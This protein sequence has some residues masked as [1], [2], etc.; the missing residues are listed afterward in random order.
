MS[1]KFQS[2]S[3]EERSQSRLVKR[4]GEKNHH[5][6]R[7]GSEI[8]QGFPM[9]NGQGRPTV[10]STFCGGGEGYGKAIFIS[11]WVLFEV[12]I[13]PPCEILKTTP[14]PKQNLKFVDVKTKSQEKR[15][16]Q[17]MGFIVW[18]LEE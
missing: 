7:L 2:P 10:N 6:E 8:K 1:Y 3:S 18:D 5:P 14:R 15:P 13:S 9:R 11:C 17:A 12:C 16:T 4:V